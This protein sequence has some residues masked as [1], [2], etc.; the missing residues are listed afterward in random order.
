MRRHPPSIPS[1]TAYLVGSEFG[2]VTAV[3][4]IGAVVLGV[5]FVLF[6]R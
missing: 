4:L 6:R 2:L 5:L 1:R 3:V